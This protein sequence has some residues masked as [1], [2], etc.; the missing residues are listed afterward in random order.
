MVS[1]MQIPALMVVGAHD[2][3]VEPARV[4]ELHQ[5]YGSSQKVLVD[6]ACAGH[7]AMWEKAAHT[8]L[9]RASLEWLEKGTVNGSQNGMIRMGY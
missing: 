9:F 2:K 4:T 1:K 6:L 7:A 3:Q 8:M 5:D